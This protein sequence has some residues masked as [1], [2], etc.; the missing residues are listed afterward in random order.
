MTQTTLDAA[1]HSGTWGELVTGKYAPVAAVLAGG[2]LL[3]A[4][5]VYITTSLLPTIVGDI[6]GEQ[7]YAWTMTSFLVASIITAMLVSRILTKYGSVT[8]YVSAFGLFAAG[9]LISA[10]SPNMFALLAGRA[11]QGLGGGLLAGLGYALIQ[12][13]LPQRLWARGAAL[14]SAMWGVGNVL[15]PLTGGLFAQFDSWRGAFGLLVAT[16]AILILLTVRVIPRTTKAQPTG[17]VPAGSLFLLTVA[18]ASVSVA[19]IVPHG[20]WTIATI[21]VGI[22]TA[23]WFIDHDR[24]AHGAVLPAVTFQR[25]SRLPWVYLTVG[26]LAFGIGIEA[27]IPFF[28][29]E[30]GGLAPLTAGFL[31]ASLSLG[32]SLSQI[33]SATATSRNTVRR[34]T[35]AGPLVLAV[36][37]A[38]YGALTVTTPA[39]WIIIGWFFAL[40]AAGSGIGIAFPHLTVTALGT[41]GSE[42]EGAKAASGINTVFIIASAFSAALAGVLVNLGAD[43]VNS[44]HLL[45][46]TF[47]VAAAVGV[48][49][50]MRAALS[51]A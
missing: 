20:F 22:L 15:G 10:L 13:A 1:E 2:V 48:F 41:S 11:V 27:F 45:L 37:L 42:E 14:L 46:F 16:S 36:G 43:V 6:G 19:S 7:Y 21:A 35:T 50:A 33:V 29:Q 31:G 9:S 3:E 17:A 23:V 5:N 51:R 32:W 24:R 49:P 34:L 4:S 26:G 28:G 44:A 40:F 47:A 18:V 12:R 38:L 25:G 30:I 8:A 39:T